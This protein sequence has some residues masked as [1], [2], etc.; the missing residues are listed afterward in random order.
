MVIT[1]GFNQTLQAEAASLQK[2]LGV[3]IHIADVQTL[4]QNV[5]ANPAS[6]GFTNVTTGAINSSLT[7]NGSLFW[8]AEHPTTAADAL[9]AQVAAES[10]PEPSLMLMIYAGYRSAWRCCLDQVPP[11]TSGWLNKDFQHQ[12]CV[13][14]RAVDKDA[15]QPPPLT[16][17]H[18]FGCGASL[19]VRPDHF[20]DF[21]L[22]NQAEAGAF[23]YCSDPGV[24]RVS[25]V[26]SSVLR[27]ERTI[28]QP[29]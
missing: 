17:F 28:G 24:V 10:V 25:P 1:F 29:P 6:F 19:N 2:S 21:V 11:P 3:Q 26:S 18:L 22:E 23:I 15:P 8:D 27:P 9:I 16:L 5:L 13:T 7:G 4:F 20:A 12:T 14:Q